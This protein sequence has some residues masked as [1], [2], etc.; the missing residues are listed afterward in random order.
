MKICGYFIIRERNTYFNMYEGCRERW[1]KRFRE[2]FVGLYL[3]Y[4]V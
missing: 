1:K 3:G 2:G 4:I